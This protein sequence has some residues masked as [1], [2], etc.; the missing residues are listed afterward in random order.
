MAVYIFPLLQQLK[1]RKYRNRNSE[2]LNIFTSSKLEWH[3]FHS[4][5]EIFQVQVCRSCQH[6]VPV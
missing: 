4:Q 2:T 3:T 6:H 5:T 1:K